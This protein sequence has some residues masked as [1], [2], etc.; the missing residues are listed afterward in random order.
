MNKICNLCGLVSEYYV[1]PNYQGVGLRPLNADVCGCGKAVGNGV[2]LGPKWSM[3]NQSVGNGVTLG[4]IMA[5]EANSEPVV[6]KGAS[7][8]E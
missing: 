7:I 8:N 2:T 6:G 5:N 1:P 4:T 3:D